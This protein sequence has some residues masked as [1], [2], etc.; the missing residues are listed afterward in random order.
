MM[1]DILRNVQ[2]NRESWVLNLI[3]AAADASRLTADAFL[4]VEPM[5]KKFAGRDDSRILNLKPLT[6]TVATTAPVASFFRTPIGD[7]LKTEDEK[8]RFA[9][10]VLREAVE[11]NVDLSTVKEGLSERFGFSKSE[12]IRIKCKTK[13]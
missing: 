1:Y 5:L 13:R 7:A 10:R 3:P 6:K 8:K 9:S 11:K 2:F 4:A 12:L